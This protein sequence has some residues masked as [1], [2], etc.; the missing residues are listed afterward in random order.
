MQN[1][2][3][4]EERDNMFSFDYSKLRGRIIEK[5]G[6]VAKFAKAFGSTETTVGR[7]LSSK[8]Y[9]GQDEIMTACELLGIMTDDIIQYFFY[10]IS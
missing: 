7:K 6:S 8:S 9:W 10:E 1:K 5:F 4:R 2:D 3:K